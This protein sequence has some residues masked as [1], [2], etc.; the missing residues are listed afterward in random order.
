MKIRIIVVW[1]L[2]SVKIYLLQRLQ[3]VYGAHSATYAMGTVGFFVGVKNPGL[4]PDHSLPL[5][6]SLR[7]SQS[8]LTPSLCLQGV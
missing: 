7:I 4:E 1:F 6:L 8:K 3:T 2:T 5:L